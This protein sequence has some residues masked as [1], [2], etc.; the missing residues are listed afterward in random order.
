MHSTKTTAKDFF[1]W[2]GAMLALYWSIGSFIFLFF[3][4]IDYAF[5]NALAY[6]V[7]PYQSGMPYEMASLI[8]LVPIYI[9]LMMLIRRDIATDTT[10]KDIWI[11]RWAIIL[12]LFIAGVSI[13]VD[14]ITVLTSFF[15]GEEITTAFLFKITLIFLIAAAV[16][17][18]FFADLR[19]YWSKNHKREQVISLAISVLVLLSIGAG[20]VIIGTP[21]QAQQMRYDNQR[22]SDLQSIQGEIIGYWQTTQRLPSSLTEL[23]N[24]IGGYG[25]PTDPVTN[26][27]YEYST[28]GA[29]SFKLC[30]T[31]TTSSS[32]VS[33]SYTRPVRSKGLMGTWVHK[34]GYDC[35]I[36]TI[37]PQL[38]SPINQIVR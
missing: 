8:V 4:Y 14:V 26:S 32:N 29:L 27:A 16:F 22:I 3:N 21:Q 30:A 38:Y 28:V 15:R 20:F 33:N 25:V 10:R 5:P 36:R 24:S 35:F 34:V 9:G 13:A 1:L 12:T 6:T 11:R 2:F 17:M 7:N 18:H 37:N 31:F 23:S 19:G